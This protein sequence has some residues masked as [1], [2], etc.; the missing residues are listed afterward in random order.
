MCILCYLKKILPVL[1]A[2]CFMANASYAA[3]QK[4]LPIDK[5]AKNVDIVYIHGAYETRDAFNE[6][7]QNVH[8][9]MIEQ[10]QNDELMHKRL[11]DN[12]KKRIGEEPVIFFW[13]D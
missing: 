9:D 8:D 7:V 4:D 13:A 11:L 5:S 2:I 12:G 6:S 1:L 10:I 3:K